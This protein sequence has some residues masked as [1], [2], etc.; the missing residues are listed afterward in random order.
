MY[1]FST[2]M[3]QEKWKCKTRENESNWFKLFSSYSPVSSSF[4]FS[5]FL[6]MLLHAP[7]VIKTK[8]L[9]NYHIKDTKHEW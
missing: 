3:M 5:L 7:C 1:F 2:Q 6:S 9:K 8:G 4:P